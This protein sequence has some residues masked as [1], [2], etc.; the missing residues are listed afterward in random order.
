VSLDDHVDELYQRPLTEFVAART[1][2]AKTLKGEQA[3]LVKR[4]EKPTLVPWAVN[5]LYWRERK[6]FDRLMASGRE[7]R[8]AQ[9]AALKGK[10]SDLRAAT[11]NHRAALA[12]AVA[13]ATQLAAQA[14]SHPQ[15]DPL[16]RMLE[17]LSLAQEPPGRLG[18][19]T[20]LLQ[21]A[22][23]EALA[24]VTPAARP[25]PPSRASKSEAAAPHGNRKAAHGPAATARATP[26]AESAAERRRAEQAAAERK[27]AQAA[28]Q[29][30]E[31]QLDRARAAQSRAE[32]HADAV[33]Q[34]L[35]RAE[36]AVADARKAVAQAERELERSRTTLARL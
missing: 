18:R 22:G 33:R 2:L 20:E 26:A 14:G 6:T 12:D 3:A 28:V 25:S 1:A 7:L 15:P 5:Q 29:A 8:A 23:F 10:S 36:G 27:A 4:L 19:L 17:A 21:P 30:A 13:T 31:G 24:G 35:E 34:Q 16:S 9:I 11:T 32:A